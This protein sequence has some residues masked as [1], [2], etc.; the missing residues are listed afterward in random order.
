MF[1]PVLIND[2]PLP[3]VSAILSIPQARDIVGKD[4]EPEPV[5]L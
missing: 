2:I 5:E 4:Q 3:L 1:S